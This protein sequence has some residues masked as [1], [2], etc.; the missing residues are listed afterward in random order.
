MNDDQMR[1][2]DL[3]PE[4]ARYN[5]LTPQ[6][7][8]HAL[9]ELFEELYIKHG[10]TLENRLSLNSLTQDRKWPHKLLFRGL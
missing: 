7:A 3:L 2:S 8:A 6:E 9:H 10:E 1:L 4:Y 5:K